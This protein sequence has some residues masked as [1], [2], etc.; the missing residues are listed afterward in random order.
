MGRDSKGVNRYVRESNSFVL[1]AMDDEN[2]NINKILKIRRVEYSRLPID[3]YSYL[4]I[5]PISSI[6]NLV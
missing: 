6:K 2:I 3:I 1:Y 4:T 5:Q